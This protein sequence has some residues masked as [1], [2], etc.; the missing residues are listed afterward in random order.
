MSHINIKV[1]K[2]TVEKSTLTST[3]R[4]TEKSGLRVQDNP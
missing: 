3:E 4:T 2:T 1:K